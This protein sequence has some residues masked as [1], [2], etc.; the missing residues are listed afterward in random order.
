VISISE[1]RRSSLLK[2]GSLL[3][4]VL[5]PLFPVNG[6]STNECVETASWWLPS[7]ETAV[8]TVTKWQDQEVRFAVLS[9]NDNSPAPRLVEASLNFF[10]RNTGMTMTK[11]DP[12]DR[13]SLPELLVVVDPDVIADSGKLKLIAEK[14]F[15]KKLGGGSYRINTGQWEAGLSRFSPRC[16]ALNVEVN[17]RKN[18]AFLMVEEGETAA[19]VNIGLGE[20]FGI[21]AA[22]SSYRK[23]GPAV[24]EQA[25]GAALSQLYA[26]TIRIGMSASEAL[27][28]VR[29]DC[30]K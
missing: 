12:S 28:Q 20:A 6:M 19:C 2:Y 26:K 10:S 5:F 14:F 7:D 11:M 21:L 18:I 3:A 17:D 25:L 30:G 9:L 8:K 23:N 27:K 4:L 24:S 1:S 22:R 16:L 15:E 29:E 13:S